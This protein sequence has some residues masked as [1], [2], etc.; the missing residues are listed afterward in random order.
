MD[1]AAGKGF[2]KLLNEDETGKLKDQTIHVEEPLMQTFALSYLNL[3]NKASSL[4]AYTHLYMHRE[5]PLI[6]EY[7]I[8]SLG[9]LKYYLAP[10]VEEA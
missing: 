2:I 3:F 4:S 10:K 9:V 8:E 6:V 5:Q 7:R 1:G